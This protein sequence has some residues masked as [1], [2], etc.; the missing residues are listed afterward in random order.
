VFYLLGVSFIIN[1]YTQYIYF[2]LVYRYVI[3][4]FAI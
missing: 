4:L 1:C 3:S 2:L